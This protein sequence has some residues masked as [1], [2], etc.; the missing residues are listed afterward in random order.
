MVS[1]LSI[2][3]VKVGWFTIFGI[4]SK[5]ETCQHPNNHTFPRKNKT[6]IFFWGG[7]GGKE[8]LLI[9]LQHLQAYQPT[10]F[11]T[12]EAEIPGL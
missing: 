10:N 3:V 2:L 12:S 5:I 11:I 7:G 8:P 4:F 9:P 1:W 6:S